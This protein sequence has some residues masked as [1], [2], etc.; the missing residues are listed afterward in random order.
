MG[1]VAMTRCLIALAV[2]FVCLPNVGCS[3]S[4]KDMGFASFE[5]ADRIVVK[6]MSATVIA[7]IADHSRIVAIAQFAEAHGNDWRAPVAGTPIGSIALEFY[8]GDRFLGDLGV[9]RE[10]LE[11]QGCGYFFSRPLS[12]DDFLEITRQLGVPPS[13]VE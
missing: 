8:S 3:K 9:G 1:S 13:A 4:C 10:F 2:V 11:A 5:K 7:T 6:K 12:H